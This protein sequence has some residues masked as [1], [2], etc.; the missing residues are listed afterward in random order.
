VVKGTKPTPGLMKD[1]K[2]VEKVNPICWEKK[3][4]VFSV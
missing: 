3:V 1:P 4:V 2:E